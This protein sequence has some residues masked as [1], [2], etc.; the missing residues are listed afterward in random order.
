MSRFVLVLSAVIE[1]FEARRLE[2]A[3]SP[4]SGGI[5]I[6]SYRG[7]HLEVSGFTVPGPRDIREG[8]RFVKQDAVHQRAATAAWEVSGKKETYLGEWH[9]HPVGAPAPSGLD[10]STWRDIASESG[11]AM[12]FAIIAPTGW[13][14]FSC[15]RG[16]NGLSIVP[17]VLSER[18]Q[19]GLLFRSGVDWRWVFS[20]STGKRAVESSKR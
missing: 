15:D 8:Y 9:T 4:E 5:L 13:E 11:R 6:G 14:L 12:I 19:H 20:R 3:G 7:P 10:K 2:C 18:G 16:W 17:L 1:H